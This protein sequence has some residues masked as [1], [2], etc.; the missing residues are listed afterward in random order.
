MIAIWKARARKPIVEGRLS[1]Y[2]GSCHDGK[3]FHTFTV[4]NDDGQHFEVRIEGDS[5][6]ELL[7]G[8]EQTRERKGGSD[9]PRK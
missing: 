3:W 1:S 9:G 8:W 5:F 2:G 4:S 6:V 7:T